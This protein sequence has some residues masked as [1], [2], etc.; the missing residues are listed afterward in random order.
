MTTLRSYNGLFTNMKLRRV[1]KIKRHVSSSELSHVYVGVHMQTGESVIIKE[2]YPQS[3]AIRDLNRR[4]VLC[5]MPAHQSS[6]HVLKQAF[7]QEAAILSKFQHPGIM[8][9]LD[10][11]EENGTAYVV[12][13]LCKGKTLDKLV[14]SAELT[15]TAAR[16]L[17]IHTMLPLLD[18]ISVI[19]QQGIIHRDLKPQNIIV[20]RKGHAKLIDFGSAIHIED[21][22]QRHIFTSRSYSPLELYSSQSQQGVYSDIYSLAAIVYF[23]MNGS[24]PDDVADRLFEDHLAKKLEQKNMTRLLSFVTRWGL[25]LEPNKRC[26]SLEWFRYAFQA[27]HLLYKYK[28]KFN[29]R[30]V[31]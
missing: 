29:L 30:Q 12:T 23:I 4:T 31:Q 26:S 13:E 18:A 27:E 25:A 9:L 8:K 1:Y 15:S 10:H 28:P 5:R 14:Q 24:A 11:F 17:L 22:V 19:H 3:L 16:E 7:M 6:F 2:Y 20:D 21:Q